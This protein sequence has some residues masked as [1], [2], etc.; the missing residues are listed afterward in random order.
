[1]EESRDPWYCCEVDRLNVGRNS[2]T[3]LDGDLQADFFKEA[4]LKMMGD[5]HVK[6]SIANY[7]D[8]RLDVF[9]SGI[10]DNRASPEYC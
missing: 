7:E 10:F 8:G 1:M 9:W 2:K 3:W 5:Q 4:F 6:A